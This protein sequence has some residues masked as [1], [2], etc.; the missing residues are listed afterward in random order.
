MIFRGS[1]V[2]LERDNMFGT[3]KFVFEGFEAVEGFFEV[4][5]IIESKLFEEELIVG[6]FVLEEG[7]AF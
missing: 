1:Q 7:Y 3:C 6:S 4:L 5:P 2:L